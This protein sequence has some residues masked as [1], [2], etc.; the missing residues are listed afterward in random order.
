[1]ASGFAEEAAGIPRTAVR[2]EIRLMINA[3]AQ[4][5]DAIAA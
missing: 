2:P 4:G 1:L 3:L 5:A